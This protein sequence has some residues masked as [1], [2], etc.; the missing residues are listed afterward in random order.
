M[1]EP[2][3]IPALRPWLDLIRVVAAGAVLLGHAVQLGV[4]TG[5][6]PFTIALQQNA[7]IVFFVLSGLLIASSVERSQSLRSYAIARISRVLPV[8][9]PAILVSV[10][11]AALAS[12]SVGTDGPTSTLIA[13]LGALLFQGESHLP[14]FAANPPFW[15]LCYEIWFY[16]LFGA[17]TYLRGAARAV[18]LALVALAAGANI[19][20]LLPCWLVGIALHRCPAAARLPST[21]ARPAIMLALTALA[22]APHLAQ[23]LLDLL[24]DVA[25]WGLGYAQYALSDLL[26]AAC[27]AV[28]LMGLRTL[29]AA[30]LVMPLRLRGSAQRLADMSFSLYLFHWPLLE[31]VRIAGVSA[32][33]SVLGLATILCF[34]T[35]ISAAL[36][37]IT[38]GRRA[39]VLTRLEAL[40][41]AGTSGES[42]SPRRLH[43]LP[44]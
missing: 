18:C 15:S 7:V 14:S 30:G 17:A 11:V 1:R 42:V 43:S 27:I 19:L 13:V 24:R 2:F 16:A 41:G 28:G 4:Y 3:V 29:S 22:I 23:P 5:P 9:L 20:L 8:S 25:R 33:A 12:G 32:G 6:Y 10:A 38:E 40:F 36:A 31:L 44:G 35:A 21:L 26:L 37:G 34:V 39:A